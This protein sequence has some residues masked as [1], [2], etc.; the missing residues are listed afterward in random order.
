MEAGLSMPKA[1]VME[2][3]EAEKAKTAAGPGG[4]CSTNVCLHSA[5]AQDIMGNAVHSANARFF[6]ASMA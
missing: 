4:S 1:R 6:L 2:A 5:Q 3:R